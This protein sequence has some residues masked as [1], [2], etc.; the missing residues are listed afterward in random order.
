[1]LLGK[2][3]SRIRRILVLLIVGIAGYSSPAWAQASVEGTWRTINGTEVNI[4]PCESGFCGTLSWI[5]IPPEQSGMCK[6]MPKE[7]FGSLMLDYKNPDKA[8]QTR[9]LVGVQMLTLKPTNDPNA[10]TASVYNAE[11]G[12]TNDVLVWVLDNSILRL[13][14]GCVA[15]L[16]AVTQDWP[17][18]ADRVD[19]PDFTCS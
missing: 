16:C 18:V 4:V 6:M 5:V 1:M 14:G 10:Y 17:R 2:L 3:S 19:T 12:S 11:D 13:G 15:S 9:S 8:L 7:D